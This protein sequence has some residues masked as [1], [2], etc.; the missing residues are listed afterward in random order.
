MKNHWNRC[1]WKNIDDWFVCTCTCTMSLHHQTQSMYVMLVRVRRVLCLRE[2]TL[3]RKHLSYRRVKTKPNIGSW[4]NKQ[5]NKISV[6]MWSLQIN[7]QL[8]HWAM[9]YLIA[10]LSIFSTFSMLFFL[11]FLLLLLFSSMFTANFDCFS[12]F[13][14]FNPNI[15]LSLS[16]SSISFS[17]FLSHFAFISLSFWVFSLSLSNS[18]LFFFFILS[19]TL[20]FFSL[21]RVLFVKKVL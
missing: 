13:L 8:G 18:V 10:A 20:A 9:R 12:L 1:I 17:L 4:T 6:F 11:F 3:A 19:S 21:K 5:T 16:L 7:M 14:L 15:S 2:V